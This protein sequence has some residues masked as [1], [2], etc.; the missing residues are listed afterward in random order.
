MLLCKA[1]ISKFKEL[2]YFYFIRR[3]SLFWDLFSRWCF[4][5]LCP[6]AGSPSCG[7]VKALW[8][9]PTW[10]Q[11]P[12]WVRRPYW[13]VWLDSSGGHLHRSIR[14]WN[15]D[16]FRLLRSLVAPWHTDFWHS[17]Y[18]TSLL[19]NIP[20]W[21][22]LSGWLFWRSSWWQLPSHR[23]LKPAGHRHMPLC[24]ASSCFCIFPE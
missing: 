20:P 18:I 11:M 6:Y 19:P 8:W 9:L 5:T 13:V 16:T 3:R 23:D 7:G 2:N 15:T 4:G 24:L 17:S 21:M 22:D 10:F 14:K 12:F 1:E